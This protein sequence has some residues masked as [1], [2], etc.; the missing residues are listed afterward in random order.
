MKGR[1]EST[2]ILLRPLTRG[3]RA[4]KMGSINCPS[5]GGYWLALDFPKNSSVKGTSST[6]NPNNL[7][8]IS[9]GCRGQVGVGEGLCHKISFRLIGRSPENGHDATNWCQVSIQNIKLVEWSSNC[10][11]AIVVNRKFARDSQRI[12]P[13]FLEAIPNHLA[14]LKDFERS[15]RMTNNFCH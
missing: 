7:I 3:D 14:N 6:S 12:Y 11:Q 1:I 5:P 2:S 4:L 13:H 10:G 15:N 8:D 9:D